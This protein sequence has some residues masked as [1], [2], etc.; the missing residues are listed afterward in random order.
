[1][2]FLL[3]ATQKHMLLERT[4]TVHATVAQLLIAPLK[5]NLT[6]KDSRGG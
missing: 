4:G 2:A 1:M 6:A 5:T 3:E